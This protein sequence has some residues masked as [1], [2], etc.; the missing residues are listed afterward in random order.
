MTHTVIIIA[1]AVAMTIGGFW[2]AYEGIDS[3]FV[4]IALLVTILFL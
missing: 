1:L 3:T 2:M 4:W